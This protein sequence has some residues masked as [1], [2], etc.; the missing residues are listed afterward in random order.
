MVKLRNS[1]KW[2]SDAGSLHWEESGVIPLSYCAPLNRRN[3]F[4]RRNGMHDTSS[5]SPFQGCIPDAAGL[6]LRHPM[7]LHFFRS[8]TPRGST[9]SRH[10]SADRVF[11]H[12]FL[13]LPTGAV[14]STTILVHAVTQSTSS[15]MNHLYY[16]SAMLYEGRNIGNNEDT[17]KIG[18]KWT[19]WEC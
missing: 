14:S 13:G 10:M 1:S 4:L 8:W 15:D 18:L 17:K 19:R 3:K 7:A 11:C 5:S 12:V 16:R 6:A 9:F 2:D